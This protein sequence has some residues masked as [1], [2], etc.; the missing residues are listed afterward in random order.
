MATTPRIANIKSE[1]IMQAM[2]RSA[3][4][5][6]G[7]DIR[8]HF[9]N[10]GRGGCLITIGPEEGLAPSTRRPPPLHRGWIVL[11]HRCT[12]KVGTLPLFCR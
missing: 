2:V 10:S 8:D 6:D 4:P 1:E 3:R 12:A 5:S 11:R 9:G 7:F